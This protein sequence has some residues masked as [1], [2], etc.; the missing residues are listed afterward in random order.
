MKYAVKMGLDGMTYIPDFM[1]FS[2]DIQVVLRLVPQQSQKVQ[3][4]YYWEEWFLKQAVK[5]DS[6][7]MTC[8]PSLIKT[9]FEIHVLLKLWQFQRPLRARAHAHEHARTHTHTHKLSADWFR[10]SNNK[11]IATKICKTA[12]LVLLMGGSYE[13][14]NWVGLGSYNIPTKFHKDEF[15]CS[16]VIGSGDIHTNTET[17]RWAHTTTFSSS[18]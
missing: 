5:M 8:I 14:H 15:R 12:M 17:A 9:D 3:C 1:T 6:G 2:L 4:C 7:G 10:Y 16:K 18:K 13:I 11:I